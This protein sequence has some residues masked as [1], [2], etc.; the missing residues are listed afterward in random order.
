MKLVLDECGHKPA[1]HIRALIFEHLDAID[2]FKVLKEV[3]VKELIGYGCF[4][5]LLFLNLLALKVRNL[6]KDLSHVVFES[7]D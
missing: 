7:I 1:I 6:Q 4:N 5:L 3:S 2:E